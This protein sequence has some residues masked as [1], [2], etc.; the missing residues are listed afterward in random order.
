[1]VIRNEPYV[2][3]LDLSVWMLQANEIGL[4]ASIS[5]FFV[6][7]ATTRANFQLCG[8]IH[9]ARELL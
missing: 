8:T 3:S 6:D 9:V 7:K 5:G 2:C 4:L 1:M